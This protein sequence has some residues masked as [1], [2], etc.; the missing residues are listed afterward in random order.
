MGCVLISA[1]EC[2]ACDL[3]RM[4]TME[5]GFEQCSCCDCHVSVLL[6][7]SCHFLPGAVMPSVPYVALLRHPC[8]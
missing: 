3:E 5:L 7:R 6:C 1:P 2:C 4:T 8:E